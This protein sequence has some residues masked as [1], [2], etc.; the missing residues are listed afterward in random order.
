MG[1][2]DYYNGDGGVKVMLERWPPTALVPPFTLHTDT[3]GGPMI[4]LSSVVVTGDW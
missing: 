4:S 2:Q 3:L 1:R